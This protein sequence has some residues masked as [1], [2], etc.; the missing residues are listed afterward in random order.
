MTPASSDSESALSM[1]PELTKK[2]PPGS[3][4]ALTSSE[5]STLMV[6]GT[7]ASEF[8][9][10]FCPTRLTYSAMMGSSIILAWRSTSCANCL[11]IGIEHFD[12]EG[13]LGIGVS[14]EILPDAVDVFGDDGVVDNLGMALHFL[15][16]LLADRNRAL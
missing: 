7:L 10:R 12:G 2:N 5:S 6:K 16:Q 8:R 1:R 3:A 13:D 4:K 14:D 15:R 9:T 11:Q